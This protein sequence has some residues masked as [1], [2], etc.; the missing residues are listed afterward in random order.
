[1]SIHKFMF[2]DMK[3]HGKT[4][5]DKTMSA[6]EIVLEIDKHA[7]GVFPS[8]FLESIEKSINNL[9]AQALQQERHKN[10]RLTADIAH[11]IGY[12]RGL[13]HPETYLEK[14]YPDLLDQPKMECIRWQLMTT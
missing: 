4:G 8:M 12:C 14:Q 10:N 2:Q 13:G 6:I 7:P 1:M 11:A 9:L 5:A 3:L